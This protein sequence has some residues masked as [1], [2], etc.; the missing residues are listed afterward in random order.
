MIGI[1]FPTLPEFAEQYKEDDMAL[2]HKEEE[3][4]QYIEDFS[5]AGLCSLLFHTYRLRLNSS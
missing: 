1:T 4:I 5:L 2:S 3:P